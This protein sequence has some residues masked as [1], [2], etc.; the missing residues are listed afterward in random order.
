[1][2]ISNKIK[3]RVILSGGGVKGSFQLGVLSEII[4]SKRYTIDKV[5]GCSIGAIISPLL[6]NE[7]IDEMINIFDNIKSIDDVIERRRFLGMNLPNWK[8]ILFTYAILY[9]GA[10]KNIK[11]VYTMWNIMSEEEISIAKKK[12]HVVSY[13]I[14]NNKEVWFTGNELNTGIKCSSALWLA[15]PPIKYKDGLYTDG[16]VTEMFSVDYILD[17]EREDDFVGEYIF[18]DCDPRKQYTNSPPSDG[19]TLMTNL[20]NSANVKLAHYEFKKLES[21]LKNKLTI[22][23]PELNMFNNSLDI[24][25]EKM[26]ND[27]Q[28]LIALSH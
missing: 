15:V 20:H 18:I 13:D 16:G 7:N 6:A 26:K 8:C 25:P 3:L 4:K 24:D 5:Y 27:Y 11:L 17:Q 12:C 28:K 23:R 22:L 14:I 19:L 1:M 21:N 2:K 9:L 10:Y